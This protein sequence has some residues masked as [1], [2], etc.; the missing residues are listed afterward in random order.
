MA[1][2]QRLNTYVPGSYAVK[3][4]GVLPDDVLRTMEE[5]GIRYIPRDGSEVE[6]ER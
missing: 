2:F 4:V 5:N 6:D 1:R 3:V